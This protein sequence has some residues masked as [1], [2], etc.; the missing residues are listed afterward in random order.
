MEDPISFDTYVRVQP[1]EVARAVQALRELRPELTELEAHVLANRSVTL[2]HWILLGSRLP[3]GQATS[4]RATAPTFFPNVQLV[5][6]GYEPSDS[7]SYCESHNLRFAGVLGCPVC[8][9]FFVA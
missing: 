3:W 5:Q 4:M 8:G 2:G 7:L 9:G 6:A 1:G